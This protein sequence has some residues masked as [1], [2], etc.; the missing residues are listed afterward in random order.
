MHTNPQQ[1]GIKNK[2]AQG[3]VIL[4]CTRDGVY[5]ERRIL[6]FPPFFKLFRYHVIDQLD[7]PEKRIFREACL[8]KLHLSC[9]TRI[10]HAQHGIPETGDVHVTNIKG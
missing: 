10:G 3:R 8:G 1:H 5:F 6:G 9:E 7:Q 4:Q 2:S